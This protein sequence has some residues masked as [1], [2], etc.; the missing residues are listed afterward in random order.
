MKRTAY[1]LSLM[2]CLSGC[3]TA[4]PEPEPVPEDPP[5]Y[6]SAEAIL[7]DDE[8]IV[9][10][11]TTIRLETLSQEDM[12]LLFPVFQE[13][14]TYYSKLFDRY[15]SFAEEG[16]TGIYEINQS[17]GTPVHVCSELFHVIREAVQLTVLTGGKYNLTVGR[18]YDVWADR[19]S[20]FPMELE[21]PPE[22]EI[23]SALGCV[24]KPEDLSD[25]I[26]LDEENSTVAIMPYSSCDTSVVLDAGALAKGY[27]SEQIS[28]A[29]QKYEVPFLINAGS[30]SISAY[31]PPGR[32]KNWYVGIRNPYA[33]VYTLYDYTIPDTG[34]FSTSGDDSSYFILNTEDGPLI[35]HHILNPSTG[36]PENSI[37]MASVSS[38]RNGM[39][40]DVLTTALFNTESREERLQLISVLSDYGDMNIEWSWFE[41]TGEEQGTL[42][43]S[44]AFSEQ[45]PAE[46]ISENIAETEVIP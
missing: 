34:L 9:P 29:L 39:L 14:I 6:A 12:D 17:D 24:V 35:R 31:A 38:D 43:S 7:R 21:D 28:L 15:H 20:P 13:Q 30:S 45:I 22:E 2:L 26:V 3:R 1:L 27:A 33:R 32:N 44:Q 11:N 23:Q 40:C 8:V 5:V 4:E 19:F 42:C 36:Y 37:R 25:V 18:L 41:E 10:F 46:S 16:I